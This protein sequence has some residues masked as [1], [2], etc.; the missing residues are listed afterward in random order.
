MNIGPGNVIGA[1]A[2]GDGAKVEGTVTIGGTQPKPDTEKVKAKV[3]I[4]A[5][6]PERAAKWLRTMAD[7]IEGGYCET[8]AKT[9]ADGASIAWTW[10]EDK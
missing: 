9:T 8:F 10:G 5:A 2:M 6:S 1:M 7:S 4:K 3:E